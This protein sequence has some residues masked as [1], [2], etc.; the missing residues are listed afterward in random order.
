MKQEPRRVYEASAINEARAFIETLEAEALP[1]TFHPSG[2]LRNFLRSL[3]KRGEVDPMAARILDTGMPRQQVKAYVD[4]IATDLLQCLPLAE[5]DFIRQFPIGLVRTGNPNAFPIVT[6]SGV[7]AILLDVWFTRFV[8]VSNKISLCTKGWEDD[9]IRNLALLN[10]HSFLFPKD[11]DLPHADRFFGTPAFPTAEVFEMFTRMTR[12]QEMFVLAH[13]YSHVLLGHLDNAS[14]SPRELI[15][16]RQTKVDEVRRNHHDEF[17]ADARA[18]EWCRTVFEK[19]Y[20]P[21]S[22]D[23]HRVEISLQ[24]AEIFLV[25]CRIVEAVARNLS[26]RSTYSDT[27][28]TALERLDRMRRTTSV[29]LV[30][31]FERFYFE[32]IFPE[33]SDESKPEGEFPFCDWYMEKAK[34]MDISPQEIV[35]HFATCPKCS[36]TWDYVTA[37]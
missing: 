6:P 32:K 19:A 28:P 34:T 3:V 10:V 33:I 20:P 13:E 16:P 36:L 8:G 31:S 37:R 22:T 7:P 23:D 1:A 9:E 14:L 4:G 21:V 29:D 11:P 24:S 30:T 26:S 17:E 12:A 18:S 15:S 27:H 35:E 5:R 25:Y 2:G